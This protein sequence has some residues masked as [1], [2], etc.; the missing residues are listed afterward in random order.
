MDLAF[1]VLGGVGSW[2]LGSES[3]G[4]GW[5]IAK[6]GGRSS[7][8]SSRDRD[9]GKAALRQRRLGIGEQQGAIGTETAYLAEEGNCGTLFHRYDR[10][11]GGSG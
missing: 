5:S 9:S 11:S 3:R 7:S 2:A 6:A 4:S 10:K 1:F 8:S